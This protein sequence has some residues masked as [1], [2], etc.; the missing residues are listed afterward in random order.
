MQSPGPKHACPFGHFGHSDPPQSMPLSKK[1]AIPSVQPETQLF[2]WQASCVPQL[3]ALTHPTQ[4]PFPSQ[5]GKPSPHFDPWSTGLAT[6]LLPWHDGGF[7]Q[8]PPHVRSQVV[9]EL[10]LAVTPAAPLPAAD[11]I[12][13]P[14]PVAAEPCG[15]AMS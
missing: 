2:F 6:H 15:G 12:A 9:P 3:L 13:P 14:A 10:L 8:G 7:R 4:W 5:T 11:P 1:S